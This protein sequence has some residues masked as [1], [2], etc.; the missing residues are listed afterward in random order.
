MKRADAVRILKQILN[1]ST[2]AHCKSITL[3]LH[4]KN[5]LSKGYQITVECNDDEILRSRV[6][7]IAKDNGLMVEKEGTSLIVY[8]P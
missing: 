2:S 6:E 8:Q 7:K 1:S 4:P 3:L 5:G